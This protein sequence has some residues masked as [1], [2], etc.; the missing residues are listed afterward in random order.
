[1][2]KLA[3]VQSFEGICVR[4]TTKR[5]A[6]YEGFCHPARRKGKEVVVLSKLA[7]LNKDGSPKANPKKGESRAFSLSDLVGIEVGL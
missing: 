2:L 5:G 6:K 4:I 7:I 1:M 3:E